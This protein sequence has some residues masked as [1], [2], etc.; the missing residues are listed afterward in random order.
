MEEWRLAPN[1]LTSSTDGG[2][3]SFM[4][5]L[6]HRFGKVTIGYRAPSIAKNTERRIKHIYNKSGI[7]EP[8]RMQNTVS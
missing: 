6:L 4:H 5:L 2:V 1:F 3:V 7:L 8:V